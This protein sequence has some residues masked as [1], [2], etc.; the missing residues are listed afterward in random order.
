[1]I[2]TKV[3]GSEE[4]WILPK[5]IIEETVY[6]KMWENPMMRKV[7][8]FC[9]IT[10][11]LL[12]LS[13]GIIS[14][15]K[16][17]ISNFNW[18][19]A[20]IRN[21]YDE[22][23]GAPVTA[24]EENSTASLVVNIYNS[25]YPSSQINVSAVKV[26]FD[27]GQNYTSTECST[28]N[29]VQIAYYQ[30]HVFTVTFT[31]PSVSSASNFV[32]HGYTIYVEHVNSTAGP[33]EIVGQW[34]DSESGFAI[35]SA[36]QAAAY[37]LKTQLESYPSSYFFFTAKARELLTT[38]TVEKNAAGRYYDRGSFNS[39]KTHYQNAITLIQQAYS[40]ETQKFSGFE[41][42]F[43]GLLKGGEN[44]LNMEGYAWLLF[45]IGFVL[46]SIGSLIF[47]SRKRP[48]PRTS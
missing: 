44:L 8:L 37:D 46:I 2:F 6:H 12:I 28:S 33:K 16:A 41:D 17:S 23:Y 26:G 13:V 10:C 45:G 38:S 43:A 25:N 22:F 11:V 9:A 1:M 19:G 48:T 5:V 18:I 29:P 42:A 21:G 30:S 4:S 24:Y 34:T 35:F 31:V 36:D 32:T 3:L 39:A 15:V 40:N 20:I 7:T 47:L 27:W 14:P